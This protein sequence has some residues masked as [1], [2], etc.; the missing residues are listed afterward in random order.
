LVGSFHHGT[1]PGISTVIVIGF[2]PVV[3]EQPHF[4]QAAV[5]VA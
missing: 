4:L 2:P 3:L 1:W 5:C